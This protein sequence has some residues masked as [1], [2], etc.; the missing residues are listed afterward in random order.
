MKVYHAWITG[1]VQGVFFRDSTRA[2]AQSLGLVGWVRNVSDGRVECMF[3]GDDASTQSMLLWL[4]QGPDAARVDD[5]QYQ[6][7]TQDLLFQDFTVRGDK[8]CK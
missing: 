4:Q 7:E 3:A 5:I 8:F 6:I 1:K 2:Q